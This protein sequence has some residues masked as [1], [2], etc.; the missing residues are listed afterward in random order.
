MHH[1]GAGEAQ[2]Y[3]MPDQCW[4]LEY[5]RGNIPFMLPFGLADTFFSTLDFYTLY[6]T[7]AVY[8][9]RVIAELLQ[10]KIWWLLGNNFVHAPVANSLHVTDMNGAYLWSDVITLCFI[11]THDDQ[12]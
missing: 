12:Q 2:A 9:E 10:G 4:A 11:A 1:L 5:A 7:F 8:G 3:R 6:K